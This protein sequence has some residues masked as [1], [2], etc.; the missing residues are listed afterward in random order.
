MDVRYAIRAFG[1]R[2]LVAAGAIASLAVGIAGTT[3]VF[4]V[5]NGVLL[6]DVPGVTRPERLVEIARDIGGTTADVTFPMYRQL[7]EQTAI[8]DDLAA[9]VLESVSIGGGG[10]DAEPSVR[11]ALAVTDNYF[12]ILGV[13]AERG[14]V[15]AP[16]Q[17][18]YPVIAPVVVIS[19]DMWQREFGGRDDVV[20][21]AARVNGTPVEIIGVLPRG[22]AGHHTGLLTDVFLPLGLDA[23][24]L[25]D[26][27]TFAQGNQSSVEL[28]GRLREGITPVQ[29]TRALGTA[30]DAFGREVGESSEQ[31]P[32]AVAVAEWGPLPYTVRTAVGA[33]LAVLL[34]LAGLGLAMACMNVSTILLAQASERQ[35]E[36]AVRR[37]VG[38]GQSRLVR[39]IVTEVGVLFVVA[40][41]IGTAAALWATGLF[42]AFELPVPVPGRLGADFGADARV[43]AFSFALT[44]VAALTFSLLPAFQSSRFNVVRALREMGTAGTRG[45]SRLRSSLVGAQVAVTTVLLAATMLFGRALANMR[46]LEHGWNGDGVVVA[47]ID[48]ELNGTPAEQG[49]LTQRRMLERVSAIPGVEVAAFATKLP[50]AGRS[51]FG[52]VRVPGVEAPNGLPGFDAALNRVSPGYFSAMGIPLVSGRD[53]ESTDDERSSL[54]AVINQSM[55]RRIWPGVDPVGR[56]FLIDQPDNALEFR[57]VG[58]AADAHGT[59]PGRPAENFYYVPAEQWYN[60]S[61]VLHVRSRPDL[62]AGVT[63]A[64]RQALRDTDPSLPLPVVRPLNEV[65]DVYFMPQRLAAWASGAMGAFGLL[66]ALVGIYGT[67][68]FL[69]SRR[70]REMAIRMALG[71]TDA[72]VV[73]MIV[74]R[75]GRA[76]AL[77]LAIGMLLG[78]A[79][80]LVASNVVAGARVVDPVAMAAVPV[81][82]AL[83]TALAMLTPLRRLLRAPLAPRMRDD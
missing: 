64:V 81:V 45:R 72:D 52:L 67:T 39:Q 80:A 76:P 38:A 54:V 36:L 1:R 41:A 3:V 57:I 83:T 21:L 4:S 27:A 66:L 10:A 26:A 73:R 5:V 47:P 74:V 49:R 50:M 19:H 31:F 40:G 65:L 6:K 14:R 35:R 69:V 53:I 28:L 82:L 56:S 43:L 20:G 15:F 34:L 63:G 32:Y 51:S 2:P 25:P 30:A 44:L 13:T 18:S 33:F 22:F 58:V 17:A 11:G 60:S 37:A 12:S 7:G 62:E 77:G 55:A 42:T 78:T 71:A 23:P 46:T 9:L 59:V 68:A 8:L 16:G 61:V 79:L 29:A 48:L 24:G 70:A 75:G